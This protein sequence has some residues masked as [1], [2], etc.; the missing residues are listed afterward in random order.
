MRESRNDSDSCR[1]NRPTAICHVNYPQYYH[2]PFQ[3]EALGTSVWQR[4]SHARKNPKSVTRKSL[5][6]EIRVKVL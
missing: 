3:S 5:Y 6:G 1:R 2:G 4:D